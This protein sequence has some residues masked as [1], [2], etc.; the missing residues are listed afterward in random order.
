MGRHLPA[1][2]EPS[3]PNKLGPYSAQ[4]FVSVI[5]PFMDPQRSAPLSFHHLG[6]TVCPDYLGLQVSSSVRKAARKHSITS[7]R[8]N[9]SSFGIWDSKYQ[10]DLPRVSF[11]PRCR[12]RH[13]LDSAVSLSSDP[14]EDGNPEIPRDGLIQLLLE[15]SMTRESVSQRLSY[16][17]N[18]P[19][20]LL[21]GIIE[22]VCGTL[23]FKINTA[24][25]K[26]RIICCH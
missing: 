18:L 20:E 16:I 24:G 7:V 3:Q 9:F 4:S 10:R 19:T 15:T 6:Q 17:N 13:C 25:R 22:W 2:H 21:Q 8:P 5:F 23:N 1:V 12:S 14:T 26:G 11:W